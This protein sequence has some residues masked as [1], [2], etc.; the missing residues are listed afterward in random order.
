MP[1]TS[2]CHANG[3]ALYSLTATTIPSRSGRWQEAYGIRRDVRVINLSL[4]NAPW[5]IKQLMHLEPRVPVSFTDDEVKR[6]EHV[7][8]PFTQPVRDSLRRAGIA[9]NLPARSEQNVLRIQDQMVVNIVD[10]NA[11]RKP[12]YFALTVAEDNFVGLAPF[13]QMQGLAYRVMPRETA[14]RDKMDIGRSV[15]LLDHVFRFR[16]LGDGRRVKSETA[17]ELLTNY[18]AVF[19]QIALT[20]REPLI[21]LRRE[22][23]GL[24][25]AADKSPD[26]QNALFQKRRAYDDTLSMALGKLDE[27]MR[28]MPWDRRPR[29]V[30]AEI[31]TGSG[32][33]AEAES[34][35]R[36]ALEQGKPE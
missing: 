25:K 32:R 2:S 29:A 35:M 18:G 33:V 36:D 28:L 20:L 34:V 15:Y 30:K 31:L 10:A 24:E 9:V 6:L 12:I 14:E 16:G 11:W 26:L 5:Y 7:P 3:T 8:N 27:C 17:E 1:I 21:T 19:L 13:L 23:E 4:L 22:L